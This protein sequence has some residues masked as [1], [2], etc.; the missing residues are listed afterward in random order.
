MP[1]GPFAN[2]LG[3]CVLYEIDASG[4]LLAKVHLPAW[5]REIVFTYSRKVSCGL[6]RKTRWSKSP[7][8]KSG[9]LRLAWAAD[10]I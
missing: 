4:N 9:R 2:Y 10:P 5:S 8:Q 1:E 6:A 7:A 3:E